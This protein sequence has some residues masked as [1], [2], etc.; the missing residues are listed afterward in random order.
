MARLSSKR[1]ASA[2]KR[3][4]TPTLGKKPFGS[5]QWRNILYA[6]LGLVFLVGQVFIMKDFFLP[7]LAFSLLSLGPGLLVYLTG[8]EL[9]KDRPAAVPKRPLVRIPSPQKTKALGKVRTQSLS[10]SSLVSFK[11]TIPGLFRGVGTASALILAGVGQFYML[12]QGDGSTLWKG[13]LFFLAASILFIGSLWPW[14]REGLRNIPIPSGLEMALLAVVL[15]LAV[16]L[17]AYR[18]ESLPSGLFIDQGY[19]GLAALRILHEGW[20]PFY[21][22]DIFH[23]YSLALYQL[24]LWFK[25]FGSG[26]VSLKLFYA[27]LGLLGL[28]L[29]YWTFRQL[30]GT[31]VAL[32]SLFILT[33]MRWNYLFSRDGFPTV[34]M[35]LYMFGTMAFLTY[36]V[37]GKRTVEKA[38]FQKASIAAA[39]FFVLGVLPFAFFSFLGMLKQIHVPMAILAVILTLAALAYLVFAVKTSKNQES[40]ISMLIAAGFFTAGAYTY[41]AY[42]AFPLLVI[43]YGLYEI[44]VNFKM[45]KSFWKEIAIFAGLSVV[46]CLPVIFNPNSRE[47]ELMVHGFRQFLQ[48]LGRTAIMFNRQGDPNA[49]HNLQDYRMLD[50]ISA[51]LFI[52]GLV[53]SLSRVWRRKYFYILVGFFVMIL[54]CVLSIDAA[55]ANRLFALTPF[56]AFLVATPLSALWGRVK[57]LW[58]T[59]GERIFLLLLAPFLWGMAHQNFDVYFHKQ[60]NNQACWS[61]YSAR[62]TAIGRMVAKYGDAY[63]Y[64]IT[65]RSFNYFTINFLGYSEQD[66]LH[67]LNLPDALI[68]HT[69][70]TSRGLLY[71]T[72]ESRPGVIESLRSIYPGGILDVLVDPQGNTAEYFYRV[73]AEQL[74]QVRGLTAHFDQAVGGKTDQQITQFP[75]G[76]PAGPYH[77]TLTGRLY[78]DAPGNYQWQVK[79]DFPATFKVGRGRSTPGLK[80]LIKG[81]YP[82]KVEIDVPQGVT[83]NLQVRQVKEKGVPTLL[84]AG[85]FDS[86]PSAHGLKGSFFYGPNWDGKPYLTEYDPVLNYTNGNDF[87]TPTKA[88]H[89]SGRFNAEEAGLYQFFI[90]TDSQ[91][92]L[93]IDGKTLAPL[94]GQSPEI[95]LIA[96]VHELDAYGWRPGSDV[97]DFTLYWIKPGGKKEIMPTTAFTEAP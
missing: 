89:W 70:D 15:V 36:A 1:K 54:P 64:F 8:S 24:A 59:K 38:F 97:S 52:L 32:L 67:P 45:V 42:K 62:E 4:S 61:E 40:L 84:D 72:D 23:A 80:A 5:S 76:L 90:Q 37:Q 86:L 6:V 82:V 60:A 78:V 69:K 18:I 9:F 27:F 12:Q 29:V 35:T 83:P 30:A 93:K 19:E 73:P 91:R 58:G 47:N 25:L 44:T 14:M 66:D 7:G 79:A 74:A 50:D 68:S 88:V 51:A 81:Y 63:D 65:P 75:S 46:L 22:E 87:T 85:S 39:V 41:Q 53:Y 13:L 71:T 34:Q 16:F 95:E 20:R 28:P 96:G 17:R 3:R 43:L 56:I 92:E 10:G 94:G 21:V 31:R 57:G 48:V 2:A 49:R 26:E 11:W 55:H 77:A 33:V